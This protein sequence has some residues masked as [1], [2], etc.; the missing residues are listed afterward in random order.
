MKKY[1]GFFLLIL[2][3]ALI[4]GCSANSEDSL[5]V[6][7]LV[8]Y[9]SGNTSSEEE[10]WITATDLYVKKGLVE[11]RYPL[12]KDEFFV[13]IAP[14]INNTHPCDNHFLTGCQGEL[15]NEEFTVIVKDNGEEII[16]EVLE[17]G[18]NG[19]IDLWLPRNKKFEITIKY[20]EK[21]AQSKLTTYA[22]SRTC[23]TTLKL[24]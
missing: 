15:S 8:S 4:S 24:E 17:T 12:P 11:T 2:S 14:Y 3:V 1:I 10:A 6:K 19:F 22:N 13:S 7:E 5:D 9:Y 20:G 23:I 18:S 21:I 16:N